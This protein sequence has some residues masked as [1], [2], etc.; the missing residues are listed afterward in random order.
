[1]VLLAIAVWCHVSS[2]HHTIHTTTRDTLK[3]RRRTLFT[4]A[5]GCVLEVWL[6]RRRVRLLKPCAKLLTNLNILGPHSYPTTLL[7]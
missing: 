4:I 7:R 1:M 6:L 5:V 2:Q 3:Q